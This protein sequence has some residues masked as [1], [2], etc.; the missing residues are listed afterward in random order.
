MTWA[1]MTSTE[2]GLEDEEWLAQI[3]GRY[4]KDQCHRWQ[5]IDKWVTQ[6]GSNWRIITE[7]DILTEVPEEEALAIVFLA[8][9]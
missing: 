4:Y 9:I 3:D 8:A 1:I 2:A 7:E 6:Q 5:P